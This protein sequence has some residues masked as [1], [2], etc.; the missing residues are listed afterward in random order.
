LKQGISFL[1]FF[2]AGLDPFCNTPIDL[3]VSQLCR[4][5]PTI[6][7]GGLVVASS[8]VMLILPEMGEFQWQSQEGVTGLAI[9]ADAK[10]VSC[11]FILA[12]LAGTIC[13][14]L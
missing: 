10:I 5:F 7:K 14:A 9:P 4:F 11:H 3:L 12:A 6:P 1:S 8:D 2:S 13:I